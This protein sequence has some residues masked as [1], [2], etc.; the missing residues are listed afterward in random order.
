MEL[1]T[2]NA[3]GIADSFLATLAVPR[4]C[5]QGR[6]IVICGGGIKYGACAW[7]LIRLLRHLGC[8]LPI[9]VWCL[10]DDEFD[11]DWVSMVEPL[12]VRCVNAQE[13]AKSHPHPRLGGW[14]LKPYAILHSRFREVLFLDADNVPVRDPTYMFDAPAYQATGTVFWPDPEVF[15]TPLDSPLWAVFG[16][17]PQISP[18]QESGQLLIDKFRCW[19]A[20]ELCNWYN[21]HSDFYYRHV[22][23]DKETFRFAWQRLNQPISWPEKYASGNL[24]F[25]LQQHDFEGRVLFQ[26]RFYRK[27]SLYGHNTSIPGFEHEETC[28]T[29]L[30]ELRQTWKP[31]RHL[32][33]HVTAEDNRL[34]SSI[35]G[36]R[37]VYDRL[38]HNRWPIRLG[39][40]GHILEGE[41]PNAFFWWCEQKQLLL[42]GA[43]GRRRFVLE[44]T[45]SGGWEGEQQTPRRMKILLHPLTV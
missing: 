35:T 14:E 31:Q 8:D 39:E 5:G 44:P 13:V 25:T 28:L 9:E 19:K 22:Y 32:M 21:Q 11:P 1:S 7:V 41:G 43:D 12:G 16:A 42:A 20:L 26:H 15:N 34:M 27:W 24:F 6:G 2:G 10:D 45:L 37:F 36:M 30:D 40:E 4:D 33:R 38:G 3:S 29:F 23:G 18:D 17:Q